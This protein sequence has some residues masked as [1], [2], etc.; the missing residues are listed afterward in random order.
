M[1]PG[2]SGGLRSPGILQET[3]AKLATGGH[4]VYGENRGPVRPGFSSWFCP[5]LDLEKL[6]NFS[7]SPITC[8]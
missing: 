6:P 5:I 2:H 3:M 4:M 8:L 7:D 1:P